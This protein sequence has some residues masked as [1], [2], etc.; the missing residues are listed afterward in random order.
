MIESRGVQP[1][2]QGSRRRTRA[3]VVLLVIALLVVCIP[4]FG[5]WRVFFATDVRVTPGEPV[6]VEIPDGAD[7]ALIAGELADAGVI[8]NVAM[9]RLRARVDGI[10]GKLRSGVY[11]LETGMEHEAIV[12]RLLAG[13]PVPYTTVTIPEGFTVE[14]IAER[15]E[16]GAGIPA[17][18]F[19]VLALGQASVFESEHPYLSAVYEG[20]L[21][22]YLFPKTYRVVEDATATEV[23]GMM[24]GQFDAEFASVDVAQSGGLSMHE[25]VT[26]ASMI[27]RETRVAEER[28]IVSSVIHNRLERGMKLEV[29]ATIEYVIKKNRPRLL[30]SDLTIESPFNTYMHVGLPPGPIAS[31]GIAALQAAA[32]PADTEYL[33]YVLTST[34]GSH[35]FTETY[36]DFLIA[37]EKSREVTP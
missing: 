12:A 4:A 15:F 31:P 23:I 18:E 28:P 7:T 10:D 11:D 27:E 26:L 3:V 17:E 8:G 35:T 24:L 9:F 34:D 25:L 37:K 21:E 36:E 22:G 30:N 19:K 1:T 6:Q 32:A 14:Q 16:E 33:Y 5:V 29:D 20:S 13:P 2:D